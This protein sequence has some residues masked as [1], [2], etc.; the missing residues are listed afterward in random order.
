MVRTMF[1][2]LS[3]NGTWLQSSQSNKP[4]DHVSFETGPSVAMLQSWIFFAQ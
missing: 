2:G 3:C 1:L 4:Y